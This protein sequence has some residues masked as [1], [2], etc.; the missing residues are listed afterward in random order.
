M[1]IQLLA[2]SLPAGHD[3]AAASQLGRQLLSG[4]CRQR[5][6]DCPQEDWS[7]RGQPP[8][9]PLLPDGQYAGISHSARLVIAGLASEPF[10]LDLEYHR[11]RRTS[12]LPEMLE[13]LPEAAIR[14]R[15]QN[16]QDPTAA[17]YR[18]WTAREAIFK[19]AG[20]RYAHLFA[21]DLEQALE[22]TDLSIRVWQ[23]EQWS[24]ALTSNSPLAI[25][26]PAPLDTLQAAILD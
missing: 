13:F 20:S 4:L 21:V 6:W 14:K 17:F 2:A 5:G 3:G 11:P 8:D 26:L 18:Y 1:P 7:P 15:I 9:H 10:G 12:R 16:A 22:K 23:S 19:Q 25:T 24:F